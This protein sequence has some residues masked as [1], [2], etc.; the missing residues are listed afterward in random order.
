MRGLIEASQTS[1]HLVKDGLREFGMRVVLSV[2]AGA[3]LCCAALAARSAIAKRRPVEVEIRR[4]LMPK[5]RR[6]VAASWRG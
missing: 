5:R 1:D 4:N 6:R 3:A 2:G